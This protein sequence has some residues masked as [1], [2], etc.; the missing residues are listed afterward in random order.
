MYLIYSRAIG[1]DG[2]DT[3]LEFSRYL[4]GME[5][6]PKTKAIM[7]SIWARTVCMTA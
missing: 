2:W 4:A 7:D 5:V 6:L 3:R 1:D